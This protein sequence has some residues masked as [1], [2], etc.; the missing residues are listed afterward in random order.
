MWMMRQYEAE[1][2]EKH[3]VQTGIEKAA[4]QLGVGINI[5]LYSGVL[6]GLRPLVDL[7]KWLNIP[8]T[9]YAFRVFAHVHAYPCMHTP[10][11]A[12]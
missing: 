7:C 3:T 5:T 4:L 2:E 11:L 12:H 6:K 9:V 10:V 8:V 1:N